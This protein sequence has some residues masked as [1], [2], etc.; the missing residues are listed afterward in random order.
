[1]K[2]TE[3][4]FKNEQSRL[5]QEAEAAKPGDISVIREFIAGSKYRIS[6]QETGNIEDSV[7]SCGQVIGI[8]DD[9][10]TCQQLVDDIMKEAEDTIS[11]RLNRM[12]VAR[13]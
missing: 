3:R 7:W 5:A 11:N 1:M 6:F 10:P 13:M 12:F 2:N 8:I 4:V 9:V